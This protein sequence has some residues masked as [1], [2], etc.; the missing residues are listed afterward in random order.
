MRGP[1]NFQRY[2]DCISGGIL[3]ERDLKRKKGV[4]QESKEAPRVHGQLV[5]ANPGSGA[6]QW[7][8]P[9]EIG[10]N[11]QPLIQLAY[12]PQI[13]CCNIF[14]GVTATAIGGHRTCTRRRMNTA[15]PHRPPSPVIRRMA[16]TPAIFRSLCCKKTFNISRRCQANLDMLLRE[17]CQKMVGNRN[18]SLS[19]SLRIPVLCQVVSES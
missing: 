19:S 13:C 8:S 14:A 5:Q 7:R 4:G 11:P 12:S 2:T 9:T 15:G 16:V 6:S 18:T 10:D 3:E 1:K 17:K